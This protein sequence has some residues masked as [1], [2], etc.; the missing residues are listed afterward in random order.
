MHSRKSFF[1]TLINFYYLVR[2]NASL[3]LDSLHRHLQRPVSQLN[4][5]A[6]REVLNVL[7]HLLRDHGLCVGVFRKQELGD[8]GRK[9]V[10]VQHGAEHKHGGEQPAHAAGAR[11]TRTQL[12]R[13]R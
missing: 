1:K 5:L 6:L 3:G 8:K 11:Y 12:G 4:S 7:L 13:A 10:R 2:L 9:R